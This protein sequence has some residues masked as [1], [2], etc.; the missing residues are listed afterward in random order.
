[1]T[2]KPKKKTNIEINAKLFETIALVVT[3]KS[4][5]DICQSNYGLEPPCVV[6]FKKNIAQSIQFSL[7][8]LDSGFK[9]EI[10]GCEKKIQ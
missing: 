2:K 9:R 1:M 10:R 7:V 6:G 3:S 5:C 4:F 8:D